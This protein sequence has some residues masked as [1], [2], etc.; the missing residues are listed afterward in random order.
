MEHAQLSKAYRAAAP[1]RYLECAAN[2]IDICPEPNTHYMHQS[3]IKFVSATGETLSLL[4]Q[5][6]SSGKSGTE[7]QIQTLKSELAKAFPKDSEWGPA[8][9]ID[10]CRKSLPNNALATADSRAHRILLSQMWECY[11]PRGLI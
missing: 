11:E 1:C 2:V 3:T 6:I 9:I 8:A 7:T 5:G 4:G 10:E